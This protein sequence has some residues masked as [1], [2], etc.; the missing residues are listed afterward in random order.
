MPIQ[1]FIY[2]ITKDIS[3]W[4]KNCLWWCR[5]NN[6]SPVNY[7][8]SMSADVLGLWRHHG[9]LLLAQIYFGPCKYKHLH[10]FYNMGWN[11]L[12][13][14]A[15]KRCTVEVLEMMINFIPRLAGCVIPTPRRVYLLNLKS[16]SRVSVILHI[17]QN[18]PLNHECVACCI[19]C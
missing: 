19:L 9:P 18:Y 5:H 2:A 1:V 10:P 13:I 6:I 7:F 8:N 15:H 11:Y 14:Q 3:E 12:A 16:K 4:L 17:M